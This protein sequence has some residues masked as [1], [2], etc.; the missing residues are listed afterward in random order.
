[1]HDRRVMKCAGDL[2]VQAHPVPRMLWNSADCV[3]QVSCAYEQRHVD[4]K[5]CFACPYAREVD[6]SV[7]TGGLRCQPP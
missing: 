2:G 6:L 3:G 4:L 7:L 5:W 1:M